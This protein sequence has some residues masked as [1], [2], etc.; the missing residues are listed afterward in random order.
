VQTDP[1]KAADPERTETPFVLQAAELTL[2]GDPLA[3][4]RLE[5]L[6][7]ARDER[8]QPVRLD[9]TRRGLTLTR[10][11]LHYINQT[12]DKIATI[13]EL[14]FRARNRQLAILTSVLTVAEV[15]FA[16]EEKVQ[17]VLDSEAA[18]RIGALWTPPSPVQ[19]VEFH[20]LIAEGA[21][22]LMRTALS[23][24]WSLKPYDAVHLATAQRMQVDL[25]HTYESKWQRYSA[26][27]GCRI[28]EPS[29]AQVA[30]IPPPPS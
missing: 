24:G 1:L 9:P 6:G 18:N 17:G 28:E 4:Q 25:I 23:G 21:R 7:R 11:F 26:L 29:T 13:D 15:A 10:R 5:P 12:A 3:V 19:L 22:A 20:L 2:N 8:V 27:V 30:M 16:A 14:L